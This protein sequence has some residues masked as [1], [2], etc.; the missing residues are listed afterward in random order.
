MFDPFRGRPVHTGTTIQIEPISA[1]VKMP[2]AAV[3]W[4][5][6]FVYFFLFNYVERVC[7]HFIFPRDI[8][9]EDNE[10]TS[11]ALVSLLKGTRCKF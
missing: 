3:K 1:S 9:I 2:N 11:A 4:I 6:T 5:F 10:C 7:L 8:F